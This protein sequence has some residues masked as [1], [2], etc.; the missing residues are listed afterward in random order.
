MNQRNRCMK[1]LISFLVVLSIMA[2]HSAFLATAKVQAETGS[3]NVISL[4][5]GQENSFALQ[6]DT[7][8]YCFQFT[9]DK[10]GKVTVEYSINASH[11]YQNRVVHDA[12][13]I[14][15]VGTPSETVK[16][17]DDEASGKTYSREYWM[18]AGTYYLNVYCS[19]QGK[20]EDLIEPSA[21]I[22]VSE[23][24]YDDVREGT[25][26]QDTM[27]TAADLI[28]GVEAKGLITEYGGNGIQMFRLTTKNNS[29]EVA[30]S[31][32][33]GAFIKD[34]SG[35][36]VY[37]F[38]SNND[39]LLKEPGTYYIYMD[40]KLGPC[41]LTATWNDV[42]PSISTP[43]LVSSDD[44]AEEEEEESS[45]S[46]KTTT[47][48][49]KKAKKINAREINKNW[50]WSYYRPESSDILAKTNLANGDWK[51]KELGDYYNIPIV[52]DVQD[53]HV[54]VKIGSYI[55]EDDSEALNKSN[56]CSLDGPDVCGSIYWNPDYMYK[57]YKKAK[58]SGGGY[59]EYPITSKKELKKYKKMLKNWKKNHTVTLVVKKE[60]Y[61]TETLKVKLKSY[62]SVKKKWTKKIKAPKVTL[63]TYKIMKKGKEKKFK[64]YLKLKNDSAWA[65][66]NMPRLY[67]NS[68]SEMYAYIKIGGYYI[69]CDETTY[70]AR[71][72]NFRLKGTISPKKILDYSMGYDYGKKISKKVYRAFK[73]NKEVTVRIQWD[74]YKPLTMKVKLKKN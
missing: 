16:G 58:K 69:L 45:S 35:Q 12:M 47:S 20:V 56:Y 66:N 19:Y 1:R 60:D 29:V 48:S 68:T 7:Q 34:A 65:K 14:G 67:E 9:V 64:I 10:P 71:D 43:T 23:E 28:S 41:T 63:S 72:L 59:D 38:T 50:D 22:M 36:G 52:A 3:E 24:A 8:N 15:I 49:K 18:E 30:L 54:T 25:G 6:D 70:D 4:T 44:G 42:S 21:K 57:Q 46:K 39:Y 37:D 51:K 33:C 2:G 27:E 5:V 61:K 40:S 53:Y 73:K 26:M 74:G 32:S 17:Y 55:L 62:S 13:N 11:T 31:S